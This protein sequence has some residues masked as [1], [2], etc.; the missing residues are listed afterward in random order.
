M[1]AILRQWLFEF[2]ERVLAN[3]SVERVK[4]S[5]RLSRLRKVP[6]KLTAPLLIAKRFGKSFTFSQ[7]IEPGAA[8]LIGGGELGAVPNARR[9]HIAPQVWNSENWRGLEEKIQRGTG[10]G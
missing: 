2:L 5:E 3:L 1:Q 10:P 7:A 6:E 8:G 4:T 9:E